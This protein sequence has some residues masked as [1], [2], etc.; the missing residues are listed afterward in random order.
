M[1]EQLQ[2]DQSHVEQGRHARLQVWQ[3]AGFDPSQCCFQGIDGGDV[4]RTGHGRVKLRV[5]RNRR[6]VVRRK[7]EAPSVD[8]ADV[9][10]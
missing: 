10:G 2:R 3:V 5:Q 6:Q 9:H 7:R 1:C 4:F 8:S